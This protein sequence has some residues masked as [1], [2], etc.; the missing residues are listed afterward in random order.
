MSAKAATPA[1]ATIAELMLF[2]EYAELGLTDCTPALFDAA[3][4]ALIADVA[5]APD[6]VCDPA[7]AA[8]APVAVACDDGALSQKPAGCS[9][10]AATHSNG[11]D[12][13]RC[14][15][16]AHGECSEIG[17][18]FVTG[19]GSIDGSNHS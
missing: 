17:E 3:V 1:S 16:R 2:V 19:R 7:P 4:A 9:R 18:R 6:S 8:P 12:R 14:T 15:S 10:R 11:R 5:A 13:A